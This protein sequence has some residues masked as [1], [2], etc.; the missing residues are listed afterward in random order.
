MFW[1]NSILCNL[2][3]KYSFP[4]VANLSDRSPF[5]SIAH[6]QR[7]KTFLGSF[8]SLNIV[9]APKNRWAQTSKIFYFDF[10]IDWSRLKKYADQKCNFYNICFYF[11][12]NIFG[13]RRRVS[14]Q[15]RRSAHILSDAQRCGFIF[16]IIFYFFGFE[17]FEMFSVEIRNFKQMCRT[18]KVQIVFGSKSTAKCPQYVDKNYLC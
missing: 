17:T 11:F 4:S 5:W 16:E 15:H 9:F 3:N 18:R 2:P 1:I 12:A 8:S 7:Q 13:V 14:L 6:R 10:F